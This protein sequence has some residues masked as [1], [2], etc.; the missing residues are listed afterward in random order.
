MI[1]DAWITIMQ[2]VLSGGANNMPG[3]CAI[4]TGS[5]AINASDTAL[6]TEVFRKAHDTLEKIGTDTVKFKTKI[7]STEANGNILREYGELNTSSGGTLMNRQVFASIT[8]ASSFELRIET[9][10]K[11]TDQ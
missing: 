7:L 11:I 6:E 4:G 1:V 10:V 3:W 5:T 9:E 2:D 8:K